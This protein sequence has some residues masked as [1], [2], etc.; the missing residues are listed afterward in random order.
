MC[1]RENPSNDQCCCSKPYIQPRRVCFD[2]QL[3]PPGV[4]D[5]R[6]TRVSIGFSEGFEGFLVGKNFNASHKKGVAF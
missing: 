2:H 1:E 4:K 3:F 6:F 5:T